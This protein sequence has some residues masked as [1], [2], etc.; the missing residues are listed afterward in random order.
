MK[1]NDIKCLQKIYSRTARVRLIMEQ[2]LGKDNQEEL[3]FA[4]PWTIPSSGDSLW[5]DAGPGEYN[6]D[7]LKLTFWL[8]EDW[9]PTV[10]NVIASLYVYGE[11]LPW[12]LYT[13]TKFEK[14]ISDLVRRLTAGRKLPFGYKITG[15]DWS[16]QGMQD[17]GV[18][19]F[20][21]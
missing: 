7:E 2:G 14:H 17:N 21:I 13:D 16:E 18:L 15:A 3:N 9:E 6:V 11:N 12:S 8:P 5:S 19:H 4:G 20:D 10:D 1:N